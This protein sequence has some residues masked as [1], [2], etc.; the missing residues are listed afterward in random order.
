MCE[1]LCI[2][3]ITWCYHIFFFILAI[4]VGLIVIL[5]CIFLMANDV[6][7]VFMHWFAI[8]ARGFGILFSEMSGHVFCLFSNWIIFLLLSFEKM[9]IYSSYKS[10]VRYVVGKYFSPSRLLAFSSS[11]RVF[12]RAKVFNIF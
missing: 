4:L 12:H 8:C 1:F 11:Y 3:I 10:F 9:F 6:E 7:H 5:I 2:L